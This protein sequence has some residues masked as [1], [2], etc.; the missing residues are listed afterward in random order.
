MS[1]DHRPMKPKNC[2]FRRPVLT[3]EEFAEFLS[4]DRPRTAVARQSLLNH[5]LKSG[6]ILRIKQGLYGTVAPGIN[7]RSLPVVK[8]LLVGKMSTDPVLGYRAALDLNG[9]A[10]LIRANCSV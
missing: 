2:V 8:F 5:R 6:N 10:H 1:S 4:T 7:P 3:T 9:R